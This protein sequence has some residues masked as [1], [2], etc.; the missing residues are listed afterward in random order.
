MISPMRIHSTSRMAMALPSGWAVMPSCRASPARWWSRSMVSPRSSIRPIMNEIPDY[1]SFQFSP[2]W[3]DYEFVHGN[4]GP[5]HDAGPSTGCGADEP[6]YFL[7]EGGWPGG[8]TPDSGHTTIRTDLL[9]LASSAVPTPIRNTSSAPPSPRVMYLNPPS[10]P[11]RPSP[12]GKFCRISAASGLVI[13]AIVI[14]VFAARNASK[15]KLQ[16]LPPKISIEGNGIKRGLTAVEAA[17]LMEQPMDKILTMILF[18]A[19][20][21]GA[22]VVKTT[23]STRNRRQPPRS[24]QPAN[25]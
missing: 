20:K 22:A 13:L 8:T 24:R 9:Y 18:A 17:V 19:I 10:S 14:I 11:P 6:R 5:V 3:F 25:L 16:Y 1:A 7:P 21:K 2:N 4:N 15:R 23:R 12:G